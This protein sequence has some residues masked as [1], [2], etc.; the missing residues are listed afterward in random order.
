VTEWIVGLVVSWVIAAVV[1]IIVDRLNIGLK[2]G[3]FGSALVAALVIAMFT[4]VTIPIV[5]WLQMPFEGMQLNL[6]AWL[7]GWVFA[8]VLLYII[9][10][11]LRGFEIINF[12]AAL[13]VALVLGILAWVGDWVK[14]LV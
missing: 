12:P 1:L 7:I 9:S 2:V 6:I 13:V 3:G 8:A 11:L 10:K 14:T 4:L 5:R